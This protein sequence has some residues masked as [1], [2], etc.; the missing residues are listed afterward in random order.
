MNNLENAPCTALKGVGSAIAQHL[1][2]RG[3]HYCSDLLWYLPVYY[4]NRTQLTPK[5]QWKA[6]QFVVVCG[7]VVNTQSSVQ[8]K[9]SLRVTVQTDCGEKILFYFFHSYLS[10]KKK[11]KKGKRLLGSGKLT[12]SQGTWCLFHA[13]CSLL[14]DEDALPLATTLTPVYK[15]IEGVGQNRLRKLVQQAF[16]LLDTGEKELPDFYHAC[17][18]VQARDITLK[19]MLRFLHTPPPDVD[20]AAL[21]EG[22]HPYQERLALEEM[23]AHSLAYNAR[24][25]MHCHKEALPL[26]SHRQLVKRLLKNLP[27]QL[28]RAQQRVY[29]EIQQDIQQPQP[30][31]RLLQ[32]DVGSGKTLVAIL[33][34]LEAVDAGYQGALLAPTTLLA[35]QHYDTLQ[36]L[37]APLG[38]SVSLF[39][40][41]LK[42][43]ERSAALAAI[44]EGRESIVVGTHALL[45][46]TVSFRQLALVVVDEQQRFG[47]AQ[48][49]QLLAKGKA[50]QGV[51]VLMMSATPIPRT[52]GQIAYR[53]MACST[54]D[55]LPPGRMPV[56]TVILPRERREVLIERI[57]KMCIEEHRQVYWVCPLVEG[58]DDKII[59]NVTEAA[60]LL[61]KALPKGAVGLVHGQ[62]ADEE[63]EQVMAEFKAGN[64][65]ILV[66]TTVIEVGVDVPNASLIVI[67]NGECM[68]LSQCHQLRGR[69]GRG[70]AASYCVLLYADPLSTKAAERLQILRDHSD[71]FLIAEKDLQMRGPGHLLGEQQSG[72]FRWR[73]ASLEKQGYLLDKLQAMV[74]YYTTHLQGWIDPLIK[75]W[76][77]S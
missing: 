21:L 75:R 19:E 44:A 68:G 70:T 38:V 60:A 57:R 51:H 29:E 46:P 15:A 1:A 71:G 65:S 4:E 45:Q 77:V 8:G 76:I 9:P 52:L 22:A 48:Q 50:G 58:S 42:T 47:V 36:H 41:A 61:E 56:K 67:E 20:M 27:F 26:S 5:E 18:D 62:M 32:G 53:G 3:I 66:A 55:T 31:C 54:I 25:G 37:L 64:L 33:S 72:L 23:L 17:W 2:K 74:R 30:M 10:L 59:Q 63:K 49:E 35:Q 34:L 7:R 11:F 28:T 6:A 14:D 13:E 43:A 40:G 73:I 69:V 39:T 12:Q 24:Y 16:S